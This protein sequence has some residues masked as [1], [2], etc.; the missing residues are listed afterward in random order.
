MAV[1]SHYVGGK[2]FAGSS[3]RTAPVYDPALGTVSKEVAL[4]SAADLDKAVAVASA[5]F[6]AWRDL[7]VA[8]RQS[9]M[10]RF[11]ELLEAKKSELAAIITAEHG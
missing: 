5:A 6:P 11:R 10:F 7:S 8:K 2:A 1:V 4:A 9:V 3:K